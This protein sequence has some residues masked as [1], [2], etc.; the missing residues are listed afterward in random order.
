MSLRTK[1]ALLT[2]A[3]LSVLALGAC[4]STPGDSAA[5]EEQSVLATLVSDAKGSLQKVMDSATKAE[6]VSMKMNGK[7]EGETFQGEGVLDYGKDPKAEFTMQSG[8][9]TIKMLL[10]GPVMYIEVPEAERAEMQGKRW[11]KMDLSAAGDQAGRRS[12]SS[13]TTS[14]RSSRSRPCSRPTRSRWSARRRSTA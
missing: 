8:G 1:A 14:T 9:E 5:Q 10:L 2:A 6:T 4:G 11:M 3:S 7:G 12:P 13:S